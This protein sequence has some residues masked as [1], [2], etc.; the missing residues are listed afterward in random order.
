MK[1]KEP[2]FRCGTKKAIESLV[3]E[4]NYPYENWML[5]WPYEIANPEKIQ[6]YFTHYNEQ[7]DE[8]KKFSLIQ[9]LIQALT[10]IDNEKEFKKNWQ[11]LKLLIIKDF[12]IHEYTIFYWCCFGEKLSD[13]WKITP[14]M[15]KV[16]SKIKT[17]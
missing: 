15:R 7:D 1:I 8:D 16:W 10:D 5:D 6:S 9:M 3:N 12:K 4:Y 13:C 17:N 2:E 11:Q 14:Y